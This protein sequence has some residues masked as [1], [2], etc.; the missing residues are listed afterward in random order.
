MRLKNGF[1][2]R[3][4]AG[5]YLVVP[6][7]EMAK[8]VPGVL[9]LSESGAMLFEKLQQGAAREELTE[10]LLAEYEVDRATA[11]SDVD[12]FVTFVREHG[13]LEDE[14]C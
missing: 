6:F 9:N 14:P 2:L 1:T 8:N 11:E 4:V 12:K 7:G 13:W 10:A 3:K 5:S